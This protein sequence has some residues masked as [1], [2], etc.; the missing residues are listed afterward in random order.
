[1]VVVSV[2]LGRGVAVQSE[3]SGGHVSDTTGAHSVT[4]SCSVAREVVY[5]LR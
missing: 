1:V 5:L 4:C 3:G 2:F